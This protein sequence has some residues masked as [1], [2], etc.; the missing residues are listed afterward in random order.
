MNKIPKKY[1]ASLHVDAQCGFSELCPNELP[2]PGAVDIVPELLAQDKYARLRVGT[3]DAHPANPVWLATPSHPMMSKL[4]GYPN[5]DL[6]WPAH[7][8]VGTPGFE[9]LPGLPKLEEYDYF[10]WK[11]MEPTLHPYSACYHDLAGKIP[12][13]LAAFLKCNDITTVIIG[14]LAEDFCCLAAARHLMTHLFANFRVIWNTA[15][16]RGI[17]P[18]GVIKAREDIM[19]LG[20][21]VIINTKELEGLIEL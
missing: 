19:I 17:D 10:V 5:A 1:V 20:G 18:T 15:A 2:V 12:T 21:I 7:C 8:V 3:K 11:G 13:G 14:G 16:M 6:Y 4:Q 9:S